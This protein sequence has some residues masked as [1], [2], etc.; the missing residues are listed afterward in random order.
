[1]K[2]AIHREIEVAFSKHSQANWIRVLKYIVLT[3]LIFFFWKQ[4]AFLYGLIV[5]FLLSLALHLF[6]RYKT[7]AWTKSYGGWKHESERATKP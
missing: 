6:Y 4:A 5:V 1:M 3:V 7:K 2:K